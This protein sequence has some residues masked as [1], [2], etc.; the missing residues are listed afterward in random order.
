MYQRKVDVDMLNTVK[1]MWADILSVSPSS[2]QS[3]YIIYIL[4]QHERVNDNKVQW[5][6]CPS[7]KSEGYKFDSTHPE[8]YSQYHSF[9]FDKYT[10]E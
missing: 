9:I 8:W 4:S 3:W 2:E 5:T 10:T 7:D 6:S 1:S